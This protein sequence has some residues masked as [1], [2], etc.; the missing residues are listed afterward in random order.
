M[1]HFWIAMLE[2]TWITTRSAHLIPNISDGILENS[3]S[4]PGVH[5]DAILLVLQF[6]ISRDHSK[7]NFFHIASKLFLLFGYSFYSSS[8]IAY[9]SPLG[10]DPGAA[11]L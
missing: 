10:D 9:Q 7:T 8:L 11:L 6:Y 4:K 3:V 5:N 1:C 2:A